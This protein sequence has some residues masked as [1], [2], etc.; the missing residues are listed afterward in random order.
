[1]SLIRD[2]LLRGS[3]NAWLRE[4]ATRRPFVRRA[5]SRF[6][7]GERA[8]DAMNAAR[9]LQAKGLRSVLTELGENVS[10][11]R[12]AEQEA[13]RYLDVLCRVRSLGLPTEVSVKLT[14]LGLDISP[15]LCFANLERIIQ[16]AG[17]STPAGAKAAP[18]GDP[19]NSVVWVDMEASNYVD[20]TLD[21][22]RRA[23]NLYENVGVCVQAYLYRT[24]KD[25]DSLLPLGANV[26]LVKGAYKE[27]AN[28]SFPRKKD[29]DE[30]YF[31]LARQLLEHQSRNAGLRAAIATHDVRL[32]ARIRE[33][34]AALGL[35]RERVEFQMLYGIQRAAQERLAG[36]GYRCAV[37]ISYGSYWFPWYMR[38]LAERPANM[39]F[40]VKNLLG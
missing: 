22:Y 25:L 6:M 5:V 17:A 4:R 10:D 39:L 31:T 16:A 13:Q 38:R 34:A 27:P 19:G 11:A 3:Q 28:V 18:S 15:D 12:Q 36:E 35:P 14:H 37:L 26:R 30:N 21:L 40:V 23:R 20:A 24:A 33:S 8:G 9:E 1:M 7:P 32:H 29:V 2:I